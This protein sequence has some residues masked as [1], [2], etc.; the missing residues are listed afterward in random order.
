MIKTIVSNFK[1]Y[2]PLIL[3]TLSFFVSPEDLRLQGMQELSKSKSVVHNP[4]VAGGLSQIARAQ[5]M[6][7]AQATANLGR[8][9]H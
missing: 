5:Q 4:C 2:E 6:R 9:T 7:I 8:A 1:Q 3:A